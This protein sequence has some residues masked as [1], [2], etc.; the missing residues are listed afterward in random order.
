MSRLNLSKRAPIEAGCVL[1]TPPA[2]PEASSAKIGR[3]L[4]DKHCSKPKYQCTSPFSNAISKN[5]WCPLSGVLN[6]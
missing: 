2:R 4:F 3:V 6:F 1:N 5:R